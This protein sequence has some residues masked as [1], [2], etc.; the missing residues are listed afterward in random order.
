MISKLVMLLVEREGLLPILA[1]RERGA[2]PSAALLGDLL[3][4]SEILALGAAADAAR[5]RECGDETRIHV[6]SAP[7]PTD[8]LLVIGPTAPARGT[9]LLRLVAKERLGGPIGRR[10][11][12]DFGALGLVVHAHALQIVALRA[13]VYPRD[14]VH[15][16]HGRAR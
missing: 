4:R 2:V 14:E 11:V 5:R 3:D 15:V 8:E 1:L 13:L 10:I 12:V 9:A 6:P 7:L 16:R